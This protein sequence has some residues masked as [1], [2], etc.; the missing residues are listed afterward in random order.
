MVDSTPPKAQ[1]PHESELTGRNVIDA[2]YTCTDII[3]DG[4]QAKCWFGTD[5]EHRTVA[6][7]V[8]KSFPGGEA[9]TDE[10]AIYQ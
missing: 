4:G 1:P 8:F 10:V 5:N 2:K 6:V 3:F 9:F 7:K